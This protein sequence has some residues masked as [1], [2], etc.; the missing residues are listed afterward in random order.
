MAR[1]TAE[2]KLVVYCI[3]TNGDKGSSDR[4]MAPERLALMSQLPDMAPVERRVRERGAQLGCA[5]GFA[6]AEAFDRIV[7]DR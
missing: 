3:V 4:T 6:Y 1:L 7:M 2:G 5:H